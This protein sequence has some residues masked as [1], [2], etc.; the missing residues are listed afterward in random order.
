MATN[1][2]KVM[3]RKGSDQFVDVIDDGRVMFGNITRRERVHIRSLSLFPGGAESWSVSLVNPDG[4][5][6]SGCIVIAQGDDGSPFSSVGLDV[7]VP[8]NERGQCFSL[9][10]ETTGKTSDG[11]AVA[12]WEV[13]PLKA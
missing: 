5:K 9:L 11:S 6:G 10:F 8:K 7:I 2:D 12:S 1:G 4:G 3:V 13:L